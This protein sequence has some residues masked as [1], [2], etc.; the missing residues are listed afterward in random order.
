MEVRVAVTAAVEWRRSVVVLRG[1]P[2]RLKPRCE[3]LV[4]ARLKACPPK[5]MGYGTAEG[6]HSLSG[7]LLRECARRN[8]GCGTIGKSQ[9]PHPLKA[10]GAA[11]RGRKAGKLKPWP[12]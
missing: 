9:K 10:K 1:E 2:Q 5:E 3:G 7:C 12:P 6:V 4:T 11:P 8:W